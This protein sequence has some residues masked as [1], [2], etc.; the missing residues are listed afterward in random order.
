VHQGTVFKTRL[1][2]GL[3][4]PPD[5]RDARSASYTREPNEFITATGHRDSAAPSPDGDADRS[6]IEPTSESASVHESP[7][8]SS[9]H[10]APRIAV[11]S[12]FPVISTRLSR[13]AHR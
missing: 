6:A 11:L 12:C 4:I 13:S 10:A 3:F 2:R 8:E 5:R 1:L 7:P 9:Q